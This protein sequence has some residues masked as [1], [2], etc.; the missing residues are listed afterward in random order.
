[1]VTVP[2]THPLTLLARKL[3]DGRHAIDCHADD[4]TPTVIVPLAGPPTTSQSQYFLRRDVLGACFRVRRGRNDGNNKEK[5]EK[6]EDEGGM[7]WKL[8]VLK[9]GN[10]R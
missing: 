4:T 10:K 7:R 6:E 5:K 8:F 2:S 3:A 1:M 9:R